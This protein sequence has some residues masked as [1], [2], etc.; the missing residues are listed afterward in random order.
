MNEFEKE[1]KCPLCKTHH[2]ENCEFDMDKVRGYDTTY[3]DFLQAVK[4]NYEPSLWV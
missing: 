3:E 4:D 2:K 1:I